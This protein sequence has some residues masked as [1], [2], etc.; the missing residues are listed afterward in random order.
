MQKSLFETLRTIFHGPSDLGIMTANIISSK[1]GSFLWS[2]QIDFTIMENMLQSAN[3]WT[4]KH[5]TK[6]A[7]IMGPTWGPPGSCR[8]QVGPM[9]APW[10]LLSGFIWPPWSTN[11]FQEKF[12]CTYGY[13]TLEWDILI[14]NLCVKNL[15]TQLRYIYN[16]QNR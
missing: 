11:H 2:G 12:L 10:T 4:W 14:E 7:R 6:I 8:P 1:N 5:L 15:F 3:W 13:R 16:K 9:Y